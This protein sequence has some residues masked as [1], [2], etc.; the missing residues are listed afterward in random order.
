[1]SNRG[2]KPSLLNKNFSDLFSP[3]RIDVDVLEG[4]KTL[5][6][7]KFSTIFLPNLSLGVLNILLD[8]EKHSHKVIA[9]TEPK[10][11]EDLIKELEGVTVEICYMVKDRGRQVMAIPINISPVEVLKNA[12][13]TKQG[14]RYNKKMQDEINN[15]LF[16]FIM[17]EIQIKIKSMI[18]GFLKTLLVKPKVPA[19]VKELLNRGLINKEGC[20]AEGT[21]IE[22]LISGKYAR[23]FKK[24]VPEE[25]INEALLIKE[26]IKTLYDWEDEDY[27]SLANEALAEKGIL[28]ITLGEVGKR[29]KQ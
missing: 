17:K 11:R 12:T 10:E 22:D 18:E 16:S 19:M 15:V 25:L 4:E 6:L 29:E 24:V 7:Y 1:M 2:V 26:T 8:M 3:L 9:A 23:L 14:T 5:A 27:L 28:E 21:T 20:L 13:L